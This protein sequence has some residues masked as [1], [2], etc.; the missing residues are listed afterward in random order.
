MGME[1]RLSGSAA[2]PLNG[3]TLGDGLDKPII[4]RS[5]RVTPPLGWVSE[6]SC[7]ALGQGSGW[8]VRPT[9]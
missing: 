1:P 2:V 5:A 9:V 4:R 6:T 8:Q 3:T 7:V